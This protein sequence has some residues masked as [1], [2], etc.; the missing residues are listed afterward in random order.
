MLDSGLLEFFPRQEKHYTPYLYPFLNFQPLFTNKHVIA[1][2]AMAPTPAN[3]P[4]K[5]IHWGHG[6]AGKIESL[7]PFLVC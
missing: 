1:P 4:A 3:A 7:A 6:G 5:L 2:G